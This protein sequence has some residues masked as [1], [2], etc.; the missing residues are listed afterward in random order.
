ML[1]AA[2]AATSAPAAPAPL[3]AERSASRTQ[4]A[5]ACQPATTSKSWPPG[6]PGGSAWVHSRCPTPACSPASVNSTARQLPVPAS[7]ASRYGPLIPP[8]FNV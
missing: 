3:S 5:M 6:T 8:R 1:V 7:M 2:T 4:A